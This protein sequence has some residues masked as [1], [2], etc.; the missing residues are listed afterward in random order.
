MHDKVKQLGGRPGEIISREQV[1]DWFAEHYPLVKEGTIGAHLLRF[2]TNAPSRIHY[3]PK[4]G[5]DDLFFQVDSSR[6]RLYDAA[7]EPPPITKATTAVDPSSRAGTA[8][9]SAESLSAGSEFAYERDLRNFL[10]KNLGELES[11]L[12]LY[13]EEGINGI[14]FPTGGRFV[15]I[16][17]EDK[18][19]K[20]VVIELTVSRGYDRVVGQILRYMAWIEKHHAEAG[21]GVRGMIVAKEISADLLLA[22]SCVRDVAL[23]EYELSVTLRRIGS[24]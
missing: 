8:G 12:K 16:L 4:A 21:R 11:G 23:Y 10:S 3:H 1:V 24:G 5:E 19:G 18:D 9:G 22:C 7:T 6:F 14:E 2:S 20:Y 17:A 15:D 13:E